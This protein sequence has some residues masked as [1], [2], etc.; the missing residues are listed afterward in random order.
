MTVKIPLKVKTLCKKY[1]V[2]LTRKNGNKR[3]KKTLCVLLKEIKSKI[4]KSKKGTK[5]VNSTKRVKGTRRTRRTHFGED[6]KPTNAQLEVVG[7]KVIQSEKKKGGFKAWV[8]KHK[9]LA[10]TLG[11]LAV[12]ATGG[13]A[14]AAIMGPAALAASVSAGAAT[15]AAGAAEMGASAAVSAAASAKKFADMASKAKNAVDKAKYIKLAKEQSDKAS[16]ALKKGGEAMSKAA[17]TVKDTTGI[18]SLEE[19]KKAKAQL[20]QVH[21]VGT[22]IKEQIAPAIQGNVVEGAEIAK[23]ATAAAAAAKFGRKRTQFGHF[24]VV[25]YAVGQ[26]KFSSQQVYNFGRKRISNFRSQKKNNHK[27][28][29]ELIRRLYRANCAR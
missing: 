15:I 25:P 7:E 6:S 22:E 5:R 28:A 27:Q 29:M 14:A 11:A 26:N 18:H 21:K 12:V 10:G 3:I 16:A 8:G 2:R 13:A 23:E 24:S 19:A 4:E 17:Q 1:S 9:I 20:E